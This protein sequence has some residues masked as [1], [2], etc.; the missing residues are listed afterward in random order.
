M[1]FPHLKM[2][3]PIRVACYQSIFAVHRRHI[4]QHPVAYYEPLLNDLGIHRNP[5]VGHYV[6]RAW[7]A[8]FWPYP[9]QH[10]FKSYS[11]TLRQNC[12][13]VPPSQKKECCF[14]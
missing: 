12:L 11:R 6:E 13:G 5:E 3:I 8:I 7:A 9:A 1:R 10:S 14:C 2:D 4:Q